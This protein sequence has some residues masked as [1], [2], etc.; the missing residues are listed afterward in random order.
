MGIGWKYGVQRTNKQRQGS[1]PPSETEEQKCTCNAVVQENSMQALPC[2]ELAATLAATPAALPATLLRLP[3]ALCLTFY[4]FTRL[5]RTN[6]EKHAVRSNTSKLLFGVEIYPTGSW[7][8]GKV[9]GRLHLAWH[10]FVHSSILLYKYMGL[11]VLF[12]PPTLTYLP[13]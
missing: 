11:D 10:V 1:L 4:G 6:L 13:I 7:H 3:V 5:W 12:A 8:N 9:M 2:R